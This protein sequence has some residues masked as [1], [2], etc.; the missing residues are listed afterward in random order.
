MGG[1]HCFHGALRFCMRRFLLGGFGL[2]VVVWGKDGSVMRETERGVGRCVPD[3]TT[4]SGEVSERDDGVFPGNFRRDHSDSDR[5]S[6]VGADELLCMHDVRAAVADVFLYFHGS[7]YGVHMGFLP[8]WGSLIIRVD[9]SSISM[10]LGASFRSIPWFTMMVVHKR[11][12]VLQKVDGTMAV[13]HTH[14]VA[15]SLGGILSGI[16]AVPKLNGLFYG[17]PG[18]YIG[19]FYGLADGRTHGGL[20]QIGVQ[21]IGILFVVV[22]NVVSTS[23]IC[24]VV[25]VFVPLRMSEEDMEIGDEAPMVKKHMPFV[26][27]K[28][29][30][31]PKYVLPK[32]KAAG[33]VEMP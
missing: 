31:D 10:I 7:V 5:R 19:L 32:S 1:E 13:L 22:V 26:V 11:S 29:R 30:V 24:A 20:R 28:K 14:A 8:R 27:M 15:G 21:L 9:T 6:V 4:V 17:A 25:Q 33:Q 2:P 12:E 23:I 16:F 18:H 3:R